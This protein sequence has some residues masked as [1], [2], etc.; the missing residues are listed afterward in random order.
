MEVRGTLVHTTSKHTHTHTHWGPCS[1]PESR[2]WLHLWTRRPN[3]C[4][5][6][7]FFSFD[8]RPVDGGEGK[9]RVDVISAWLL[10]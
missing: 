7:M 3:S 2:S 6:P 9:E 8:H 10:T 1:A 5:P 4:S